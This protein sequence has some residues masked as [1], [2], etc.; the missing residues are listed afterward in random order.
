MVTF[1][2]G[3]Q[4]AARRCSCSEVWLQERRSEQQAVQ[5][6][7]FIREEMMLQPQPHIDLLISSR[8]V[9]RFEGVWRKRNKAARLSHFLLPA[10]ANRY[11][12]SQ[13]PFCDVFHVE[14]IH[15]YPDRDDHIKDA[16]AFSNPKERHL[17]VENY[18]VLFLIPR[19]PTSQYYFCYTLSCSS[20][21]VAP[22]PVAKLTSTYNTLPLFNCKNYQGCSLLCSL[23]T[24][25]YFIRFFP[26]PPLPLTAV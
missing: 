16:I 23:T 20:P 26:L 25:G 14:P 13:F 19:D 21:V 12:Q 3:G 17:G 10:L 2:L 7:L 15:R 6:S 5:P 24:P 4:P 8:A 18:I 22:P 9:L 1:G 11:P